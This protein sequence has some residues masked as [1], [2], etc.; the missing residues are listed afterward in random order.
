MLGT[1]EFEVLVRC[2]TYNQ[3]SYIL[4][5]LKGFVIQKT[6]FPYLCLIMDDASTDGE[7]QILV[8]FIDQ[9]CDEQTKSIEETDLYTL[10]QIKHK[11]NNNCHFCFYLLKQNLFKTGKKQPIVNSWQKKCKYGALC[12]GDDFWTSPD[13]LQKQYDFME[14]HPDHSLCFHAANYIYSN[15]GTKPYKRYDSDVTE[16]DIRDMI[17][18]GGG[19]APTNSIFYNIEKYGQGYS[20]W[21]QNCSIGDLPMQLTLFTQ[22]KVAYLAETMSCYRVNAANSWSSRTLTDWKKNIRHRKNLIKIWNEFNKYTNYKFIKHTFK[23]KYE[24]AITIIKIVI[25]HFYRI[26]KNMNK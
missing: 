19:Y 3:S 18:V 9:E 8:D 22:G 12:E 23:K 25:L 13:K 5:A 17:R 2:M 6:N 11:A 7:Q 20:Q 26:F 16:C 4:D 24:C 10:I 15:G 14:S 1:I 21:I